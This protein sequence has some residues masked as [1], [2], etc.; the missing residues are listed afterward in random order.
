MSGWDGIALE[1]IVEFWDVL[2]ALILSTTNK[3]WQQWDMPISWKED[4]A[5]LI[6]KTNCVNLLRIGDQLLSG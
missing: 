4:F 6:P 5:K 1:F 2:K 3:A